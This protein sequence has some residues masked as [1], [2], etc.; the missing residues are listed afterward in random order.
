MANKTEHLQPLIPV[1]EAEIVE[2]GDLRAR[3]NTV[4]F[5]VMNTDRFDLSQVYPDTE[6]LKELYSQLDDLKKCLDSF[7]PIDANQMRRVRE[8][9]DTEYTYAS[10]AIEG[11]TLSLAETSYVINEG[12]TIR[13]KTMVEHLEAINHSQAIQLI[14]DLA[15]NSNPLSEAD[16]KLVHGLI[17]YAIDRD[18]AGRY[19][20]VSVG[21]RGTD[22][23]FPQPY[24]LQRL[25]E[26]FFE[27][28]GTHH[29][30]SDTALAMHPVQ[31]AAELHLRLVNIHPFIDGNGRTCR[32]IMNLALM[33]AGYPMTIIQPNDRQ[34]YFEALNAARDEDNSD[35]FQR[36]VAKAVK[37]WLF[38][39][40]AVLSAD[41]S[42]H[43]S[44]KGYY[45]FKKIEPYLTKE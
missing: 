7:R 40:L 1:T 6:D 2:L 43:A 35:S 36:F 29:P 5:D 14:R 9:W 30:T 10:N 12:M 4:I 23:V 45:Y 20:S 41:M 13:D 8:A 38:E 19:R 26:E 11:N 21:I 39:Y 25:M 3:F 31:Y 37:H 28:A 17:L 32:L 34:E 33:Q 24:L 22:I 27:F 44:D 18:N 16:L 15:Q 42:D